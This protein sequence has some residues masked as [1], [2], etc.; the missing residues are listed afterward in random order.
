MNRKPYFSSLSWRILG[1]ARCSTG[2]RLYSVRR[3]RFRLPGHNGPAYKEIA[4]ASIGRA[5]PAVADIAWRTFLS[6][7]GLR[8]VIEL[9]LANNRDLRVAALN[10]EKTRALYQIQR[11][12]LFPKV[13]ANAAG[14]DQRLPSTSRAPGSR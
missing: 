8:K 12:D 7:A 2:P 13:N 1:L 5:W 9:A 4:G 10:I 11:A 14:T 6:T 3:R